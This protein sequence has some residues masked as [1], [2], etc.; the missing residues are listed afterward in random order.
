MKTCRLPS[1][2]SALGVRASKAAPI[3]I[4]T[5]GLPQTDHALVLARM[6]AG[7]ADALRVVSVIRPT[8][9]IPESNMVVGLETTRVR[10]ADA[11]RHV[12]AQMT[13]SWEDLCSLEIGEGDPAAVVATIAHES[14]ATMVVCGLGKHRVADRVFGDETALR[15][16]RVCDVPVL[17]VADTPSRAPGRVVVACDF[18]ET[19]LRAARMAIELA[20]S[21]ATLYLVHVA[22]R[23]ASGDQEGWGTVYRQEAADALV[24]LTGQLRPP[25]DMVIERVLL[26]G[27]PA[28][29][30]LAFASAVRAD[31][32]ATGSH[33]RGFIAR[34]LIGSVA[35]RIVRTSTASVLV[36][37]H[38]AVMTDVG[39]PFQ[40]GRRIPFD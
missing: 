30:L 12:I 32:I 15:L 36:I 19:S 31:L 39:I 23:G 2:P 11:Q 28:T 33:G 16:M 4:A 10:R 3:I 24:A 22:P 27:D 38:M 13:R 1:S 6:I 20:S 17:A 25:A 5:D 37:P 35:T 40:A 14:N 21:Y 26:E 29:E 8:P 34:M 7:S 18:S 9:M